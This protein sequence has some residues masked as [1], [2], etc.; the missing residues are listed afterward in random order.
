MLS[1]SGKELLWKT[2]LATGFFCFHKIK[3]TT[4]DGLSATLVS[5]TPTPRYADAASPVVAASPR[6]DLRVLLCGFSSLLQHIAKL[7]VM[8]LFLWPLQGRTLQHCYPEFRPTVI[9]K[10]LTPTE[11]AL[12]LYRSLNRMAEAL[13]ARFGPQRVIDHRYIDINPG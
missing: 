10:C 5:L 9:N 4:P 3:L 2:V 7:F 1:E 12:V 6:C 13:K 8:S 11:D